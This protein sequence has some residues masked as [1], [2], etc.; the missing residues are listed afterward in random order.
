MNLSILPLVVFTTCSG[1]AVGGYLALAVFGPVDEK[2]GRRNLVFSLFCLALLGVGLLAT[3]AHL[4][5]PLRFMNGMHNPVSMIAQ[6]A[7]WSIAAGILM[8]ADVIMLAT[9]KKPSAVLRWACALVGVGLMIVT[10]F[11]YY[12][13]SGIPVWSGAVTLLMFPVG[14]VLL[15]IAIYMLFK[16]GD[17]RALWAIVGVCAAWL[18]TLVAFVC[19]AAEASVD[20]VVATVFVGIL[21][22]IAPGVVAVLGVTGK[23]D[24]RL[25]GMVA[26]PLVFFGV[27]AARCVFFGAG[28]PL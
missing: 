5:Q 19:Q 18:L 24:A 23:V 1:A 13:A 12:K 11:A 4:G 6:E 14:D 8:L 7:Y 10:G 9:K 27:V 16:Q 22:V 25:A 28:M 26:G 2:G 20:I 17:V 15:G 3:M 21:G